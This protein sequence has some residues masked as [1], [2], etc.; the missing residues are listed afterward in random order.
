VY[1][2]PTLN[3]FGGTQWPN[4]TGINPNTTGSNAVRI[5]G[6]INPAAF[7]DVG[8][9]TYGNTGR[10]VPGLR[11]P[12]YGNWD[13]SVLKNIPI[14]EKLHVQFRVELFRPLT[15]ASRRAHFSFC[16]MNVHHT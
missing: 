8:P 11:G 5:N 1:L 4:M 15:S 16:M 10:F 9:F 6:W 2:R 7:V 3:N 12:S 13:I 14:R